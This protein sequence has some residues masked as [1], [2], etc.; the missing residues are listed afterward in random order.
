MNFL[1]SE[2]IKLIFSYLDVETVKV[3]SCVCNEWKNIIERYIWNDIILDSFKNLKNIDPN[4]NY[5]NLKN[6]NI[7]KV[8][9]YRYF[10][11][12]PSKFISIDF[13]LFN[14]IPN[15]EVIQLQNQHKIEIKERKVKFIGSLEGSDRIITSNI[16]ISNKIFLYPYTSNSYVNAIIS[17][18][19]YYEIHVSNESFRQPWNNECVS[20]GFANKHHPL[21]GYQLGWCPNSIGYHSDDGKIYRNSGNGKD[22]LEKWGKGD[23][24]GA[25]I[26][27]KS[28]VVF[29]TKNG[30]LIKFYNVNFPKK[31]GVFPMIGIDCSSEIQYNFGNNQFKFNIEAFIN[32]HFH[33]KRKCCYKKKNINMMIKLIL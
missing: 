23:T 5:L 26:I 9:I 15:F 24:I 6:T 17:N 2:I 18:I 30:K 21:L 20:L 3:C 1:P 14:E 31:N 16:P 33:L 28:N 7:S 10:S 4:I 32:D 19:Y 22:F 25:G 8:L 12:L 11:R 13:E 27:M 29:F